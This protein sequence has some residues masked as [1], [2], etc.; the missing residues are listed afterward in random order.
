[1]AEITQ[2]QKAKIQGAVQSASWPVADFRYYAVDY[3]AGSDTNLGYSDVDVP[4]AGAVAKK[5]WEGLQAILPQAGAGRQVEIIVKARAAGAVY[6]NAADTEDA[7]LDIRGF[8][9]Y[10]RILIRGTKTVASA[11]SVAFAGDVNDEIC[12]GHQ[13]GTGSNVAGYK[14]TKATAAIVGATNA[15]PVVVEHD[16]V[17]TFVA[18]ERIVISGAK[19]AASTAGDANAYINANVW[20]VLAAVDG[21]HIS[22]TNS[23]AITFPSL[24]ACG[25]TITRY[26]VTNAD[27]SP[28]TLPSESF[29]SLGWRIRGD[30]ATVTVAN[31]NKTSSLYA[32][33]V[34]TLV[35]VPD[36]GVFI[37]AAG[38]IWYLEEPGVLF[39]SVQLGNSVTGAGLG[40]LTGIQ[41]GGI[42]ASSIEAN[43]VLGSVSL[44]GCRDTGG[45]TA[46]A[47]I[48]SANASQTWR[49]KPGVN[50]S[51][52]G[53]LSGGFLSANRVRLLNLQGVVFGEECDF[54]QC[55]TYA[56]SPAVCSTEHALLSLVNCGDSNSIFSKC[57]FT[58]TI[59]VSASNGALDVCQ[60]EGPVPAIIINGRNQAWFFNK[61]NDQRPSTTEASTT[62][63]GIRITGNDNVLNFGKRGVYF[64]G[65]TNLGSLGTPGQ[66]A[67]GNSG[68]LTIG[69]RSVD[70]F[71]A[72]ARDLNGNRVS[73]LTSDTNTL[74][75]PRIS[76]G[77][78][79]DGPALF[80]NNGVAAVP[81]YS[82]VKATGTGIVEDVGLA[83]ADTV[84]NA[85]GN[86]MVAMSHASTT[87]L[88]Y[89]VAVGSGYVWV[90]SDDVP[91]IGDM[92]YLST[93][94]AG[95]AQKT[96]PVVSGTN[97]KRRLG[98]AIR[99][100]TTT[101]SNMVLLRWA[102]EILS[103]DADGNP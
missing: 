57:R 21:T 100:D 98:Q 22:L 95:N 55:D 6:R 73:I 2:A 11:G 35:P 13:P 26:K 19:D 41:M 48:F 20:T 45:G 52:G 16:G 36:G 94:T 102:P 75:T 38:D 70:L 24:T 78:T 71:L 54:V 99:V 69:F 79:T 34:D 85:L 18:G 76:Q 4:T 65:G 93:A 83:R 53:F 72:D 40:V 42:S 68:A 67:M 50:I 33:G 37:S 77:V 92:M 51:V 96:I 27:S 61:I 89:I 74:S 103:A 7:M 28:A 9:N 25:G 58:R 63:A 88:G 10:V 14:I 5:T 30:V 84:A 23:D 31:R 29:T 46:F 44:I 15:T 90:I 17:L 87:A 62:R 3:D 91:V 56:F 82:I 80:R 8:N 59:N 97:Q 49:N 60:F 43:G 1:M 39:G 86:L 81:R 32:N 66:I 47:N 64:R 101:G 12:M